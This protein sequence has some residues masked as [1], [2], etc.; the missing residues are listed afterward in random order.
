MHDCGQLRRNVMMMMIMLSAITL[1]SL[2]VLSTCYVICV[3]VV[4]R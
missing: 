2:L 3:D 1:Y 4:P